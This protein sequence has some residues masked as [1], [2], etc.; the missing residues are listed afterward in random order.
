MSV[1]FSEHRRAWHLPR[2]QITTRRV[3]SVC[4]ALSRL[5]AHRRARAA[6][7]P[8]HSTILFLIVG[9]GKLA[10]CAALARAIHSILQAGLI[11]GL[12]LRSMTGRAMPSFV[13]HVG[14]VRASYGLALLAHARPAHLP[15]WTLAAFGGCV[16]GYLVGCLPHP[17]GAG[18]PKIRGA[19]GGA[20]KNLDPTSTTLK[21]NQSRVKLAR[22]AALAR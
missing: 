12:S 21:P 19:S 1:D 9:G 15:Q 16:N 3:K 6:V 2:G 8:M 14:A 11:R 7:I 5:T 10:R 18:C 17:S 20:C 13:G 4:R 22:C